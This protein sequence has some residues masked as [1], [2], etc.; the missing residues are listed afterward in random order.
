M[1]VRSVRV[2]TVRTRDRRRE[3]QKSVGLWRTKSTLAENGEDG[4]SV[5][6]PQRKWGTDCFQIDIQ[7]FIYLF[8]LL[9]MLYYYFFNDFLSSLG[10]KISPSVLPL[11]VHLITLIPFSS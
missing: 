9:L 2:R 6:K 11:K 10:G 5:K 3:S 4:T 8:L 1:K 7:I